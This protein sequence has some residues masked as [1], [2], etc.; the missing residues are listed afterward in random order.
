[1]SK[2]TFDKQSLINYRL[3]RA[4]ETLRDAHLLYDQG[5][6]S[7]S[8]VN[9]AYYAMFY[10]VLALLIEIEKGSSKHSG[11]ISTF[12]KHFVKTG[13]FSKDLSKA[14]HR[15]FDYR[16]MGDYR[17]LLHIDKDQASETLYAA[18]Q[19]IKDVENYFQSSSTK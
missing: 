17:E 7:A 10:A 5:G 2:D 18:K 9:R 11:V 15:A 6:S 12:D 3:E 4:E 19:F 1:M 16:Q 8:I 13:I 14:L